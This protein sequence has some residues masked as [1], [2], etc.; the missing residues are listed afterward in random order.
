M[1]ETE[2]YDSVPAHTLENDDQIV[3]K[4]KPVEVYFIEDRGDWMVGEYWNDGEREPFQLKPD[5][6]VDLW[7]YV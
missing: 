1:D 5:V 3:L 6:M 7:R 4:G 2:V